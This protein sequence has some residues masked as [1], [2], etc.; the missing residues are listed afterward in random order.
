MVALLPPRFPSFPPVFDVTRPYYTLQTLP[1][2]HIEMMR[3]TLIQSS[4]FFFVGDASNAGSIV[5]SR[6]L[7]QRNAHR[8]QIRVSVLLA[9]VPLPTPV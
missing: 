4:I 2:A 6:V 9:L 5:F 8:P 7:A 1:N 3:K